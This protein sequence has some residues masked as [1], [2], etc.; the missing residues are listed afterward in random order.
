VSLG[1]SMWALSLSL[2]SWA[3]SASG[4]FTFLSDHVFLDCSPPI[5]ISISVL[6]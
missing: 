5:P 2:S 3:S 1:S 6:L 4:I